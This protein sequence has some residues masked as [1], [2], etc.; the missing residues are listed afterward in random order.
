MRG[1][2][3]DNPIIT[4]VV[5]LLFGGCTVDLGKLGAPVRKDSGRSLDWALETGDGTGKNPDLGPETS[6]V[7]AYGGGGGSGGNASV[8]DVGTPQPTT[9]RHQAAHG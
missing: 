4:T 7:D 2:R 3:F 6:V 8:V 1:S 9:I 5:V